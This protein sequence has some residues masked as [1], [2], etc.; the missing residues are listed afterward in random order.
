[1]EEKEIVIRNTKL[2]RETKLI[3]FFFFFL[4]R[5]L[6]AIIRTNAETSYCPNKFT[7]LSCG[8]H[9]FTNLKGFE[10]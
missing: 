2:W 4:A 1:M 6:A 3:V 8:S 7:S 5:H 9:W 10:Y